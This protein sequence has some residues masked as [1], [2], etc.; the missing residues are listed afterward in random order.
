[1]CFIWNTN[2]FFPWSEVLSKRFSLRCSLCRQGLSQRNTHLVFYHST[3]TQIREGSKIEQKKCI[4]KNY[5]SIQNVDPP[6]F[7]VEKRY[8][9]VGLSTKIVFSL[10][11]GLRSV[12]PRLHKVESSKLSIQW[13]STLSFNGVPNCKTVVSAQSRLKA[14]H[15]YCKCVFK[16]KKTIPRSVPSC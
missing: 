5:G 8:L 2:Q 13:Q 7:S 12:Y 14:I 9:S 6:S 15:I 16:I 4:A 3:S 11:I 1:M 10:R